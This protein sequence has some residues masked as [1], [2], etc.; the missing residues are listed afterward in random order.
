M[1][2]LLKNIDG[3]NVVACQF[4]DHSKAEAYFTTRIYKNNN[5]FSL[6]YKWEKNKTIIDNNYKNLFD[7]LKIDSKNVFFLNQV[8]GDRII[9]ANEGFDFFGKVDLYNAD[10]IITNIKNLSLITFHADCYPVYFI[11]YINK[12]IALAHSGWKGTYLEI[13]KSVIIKM[14]EEFNSNPK[15]IMVYIGPGICSNCF[16]VKEDVHKLFLDKFGEQFINYNNNRIYID[17]KEIIKFSILSENVDNILISK[18]C[19]YENSD[20]FFSYRRDK[21]NSGG[22]IALLRMV[23]L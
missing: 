18:F 15:N 21:E 20:L 5:N 4:D 11:D 19:T 16:E 9:I 22:M 23:E 8:H 14:K 13:A 1:K 3:L 12:V 6:S 17:L 2:E 10:A 7:T